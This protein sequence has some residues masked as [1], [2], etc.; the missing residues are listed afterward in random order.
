MKYRI[1]D[2]GPIPQE[3]VDRLGDQVLA[4]IVWNRGYRSLDQNRDLTKSRQLLCSPNE[5]PGIHKA[6]K[7]I[8]NTIN[9]G[10]RIAIYGDYD[11][12]GI[13]SIVLL[14]RTLRTAGADVLYHVPNRFTEGYG[15]NVDVVKNLAQNDVKLIVTCDC[16]IS[17]HEAIKVAK[18]LGM[19]VIVTD[20]HN[21]PEDLVPADVIVNP[22]LLNEGH[23]CITSPE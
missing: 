1:I 12:D 23:P 11:V 13:T 14:M 20:H 15:M 22:K 18:E 10:S 6:V 19:I 17:N 9:K 3:I 21:I 5:L 16:G 4:A 7:I 2:N 8:L